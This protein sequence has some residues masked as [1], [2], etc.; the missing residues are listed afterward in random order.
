MKNTFIL[1]GMSC[2][3]CTEHIRKAAASVEG[4]SDASVNLASE[5]LTVHSNG[6][7][8]ILSQIEQTI[9]DAGY[10]A[11]RI[12]DNR[13][14]TISIGGMS[15]ASCAKSIEGALSQMDG[16]ILATVNFATERL[17]VEYD[18]E[19][20]R[21]GMIK[22]RIID[23]GYKPLESEKGDGEDEQKRKDHDTRVLKRK[24]T[25]SAL[26]TI[27]L[28]YLA[29][30][31][32]ITWFSVPFPD[33]LMPMTNPLNYALVQLGLVIP[34]IVAGHRF[35]SGGV[36]AIIHRSP[37]MDSLVAMGTS[38]AFI[39]SLFSVSR[40]VAGDSS[41]ADH[42][43]FETAAVI[44]TLV[45][46]GKL[47]E[48]SAKRRTSGAIK[49][50][51][52]LAPQT[53]TLVQ[54]GKEAVV[55]VH[56]VEVGDIIV[57]KPG[58]KIAVDG[59]IT[60]GQTSIDESMLTGESIPVERGSG[61]AIYAA[62]ING[63]G[64]IHFRATKVGEDTALSAIIRLVEE[65]QGSKAP[66]AL[67]G[68]IISGYFVPAVFIIALVSSVAW[69]VSGVP[70]TFSLTIFISVLLIAC[71][72]AL[73]LA[74]PTAIM[75][76]TGKGAE[77]GILIK[78]GEA[79]EVA[80]KIDSVVFD[81]TGTITEGKPRVTDIAIVD[82]GDQDLLLQIAASAEK[83][84]EHPLGNAIVNE[85]ESRGL[86]LLKVAGFSAV[87]GHGIEAVIDSK[88]VLLGNLKFMR[89]K[90]IYVNELADK[91][92]NFAIEAKT[93]VYVA[94][95]GSLYGIVAV[96][97]TIKAGSRE[98]VNSL[99]K[100]GIDVIMITGDN[101][102][103]ANAVARQAGI[104][105]VLSEVL[106]QDKSEA[107]EKLQN[108]GKVVAMVGDGINDAPALARADVGIAI[109]SGTD[110]AI[111]SADI[112]LIRG[113]VR[114][115]VT[116]IRLSRR[117]MRTIK[118]NLFWAFG[119]NVLGIPVAA[120]LLFLFGGPLLNP[121]IAAGAMSMSSVSVVTN[122]LRLKRFR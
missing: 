90:S 107:I 86:Q 56:E 2:A 29:M 57:V 72:C 34:V 104:S 17:T 93:P 33:F 45:M 119:Y 13:K 54:N 65:A 36:K 113:D 100:L 62:T 27:P 35:Y 92:E 53:A 50:L 40:I 4:V 96:A 84:S 85:A 39:Y 114:D 12:T 51:M 21:L 68:D 64:S 38:A 47:M 75:V 122:A 44:I 26:F 108:G 109:G 52:R 8:K 99:N 116:A 87:T 70:F 60:E 58:E 112:V 83:K 69:F 41:A 94:V 23:N 67:L 80:H 43:Y 1:S 3:S 89:E 81:K 66:V 97:D 32:M 76:G 110:V 115:V 102:A 55:H 15:C 120:G 49:K 71:P 7:D 28:F 18:P 14:V 16:V 118:Q 111:E 59:V 106:P 103:T 78:S 73:G 42:L 5:L 46:L 11:K 20:V 48:S 24:F 117:T 31:P 30:A 19:K 101:S 95:D 82:G 6:D 105:N 91:S 10:L 98:A 61:D 77:K 25:V 74:T 79:L 88:K 63:N 37:N 121:M 22:Q 9:A